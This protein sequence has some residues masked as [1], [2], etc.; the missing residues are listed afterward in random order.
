MPAKGSLN[1][2]PADTRGLATSLGAAIFSRFILNT[3]RRFA[4]PFAPV[5]SRGLGVPLTAIT[6]LIAVN[7]FSAVL[8]VG[9]GPLADRWGY[10]NMM[11]AGLGML[12]VGMLAAALLPFY[13][14]VMTALLLAGFGKTLFD[15]AL[16]GFVGQRVPFER[17][18]LV[19]GLVE[20]SWAA[21]TLV[22]V[23][24]IAI[25]IERFGWRAPFLVLGVAGMVGAGLLWLLLPAPARPKGAHGY[26][27]KHGL[28][29]AL[30]SLFKDR[31]ATGYLAYAFLMSLANDV[32]FV[33]YSSWLEER[34]SLG[35]VALGVG[36]SVIGAAELGGE[37]LTALFADRLG[38]RRMILLGGLFSILSYLVLPLLGSSLA[39]A[40][41][42]LFFVFISFEVTLVTSLS[43]CTEIMPVQR[44]TMVAGFFAA[45]GIGRVL[46]AFLGGYLW[47]WGGM[48]AAGMVA[49]GSA[50]LGMVCIFMG[51]RHWRR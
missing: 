18:G 8:G 29:A 17:R 47:A 6:S 32:V 25:L 3:A 41:G 16:Q 42:G 21:S 34:F 19:V 48:M 11:T 45:A 43:L 49:G 33:T 13:A 2:R 46:G 12:G 4:Y 35:V 22:G 31:A 37:G 7:Q 14:V 23:P 20:T 5:L 24:F 39:I 36:T 28:L 40:L 50:A 27:A 15:P 44:A 38:L 26:Q 9:F 30:L 10:R 51:L 1:Q